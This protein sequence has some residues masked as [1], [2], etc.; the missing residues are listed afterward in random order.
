MTCERQSSG[1]K[2]RSS[3]REDLPG[4]DGDMQEQGILPGLMVGR[5]NKRLPPLRKEVEFPGA[6]LG[7]GALVQ[8][9]GLPYQSRG[10]GTMET[11]VPYV[12]P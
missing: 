11:K 8:L 9:V 7:L 4:S 6:S 12:R 5:G 10:L 3:H 1:R 2:V